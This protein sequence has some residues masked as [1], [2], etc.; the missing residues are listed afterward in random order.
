[1]GLIKKYYQVL[2]AGIFGAAFLW[3]IDLDKIIGEVVKLP[4]SYS[5]IVVIV[6]FAIIVSQSSRLYFLVSDYFDH[7]GKL[8]K[9]SFISQFLSNFLPGAV[10]G[11]IYKIWYMQRVKAGLQKALTLVA[12][13]RLSGLLAVAVFGGFAVLL[14]DRNLPVIDV[15]TEIINTISIVI[16]LSVLIAIGIIFFNKKFSTKIIA[17]IFSPLH[18]L[19]ELPTKTVIYF[20]VAVIVALYI[21]CFKFYY[22][23]DFFG[24]T[25]D[26][27]DIFILLFCLQIITLAP[28]SFGGI[29][30]IEFTLVFMLQWL[31]VSVGDA[32]IIALLN[33]LSIWIVSIPGIFF[34]FFEKNQ[35]K[36]N[37][38]LVISNERNNSF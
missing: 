6:Q 27:T 36:K 7:F 10:G 3:W 17:V 25:I 21:R 15:N 23:A 30:V 11:D 1:M 4:I 29:G 5:I 16:F 24:Y 32:A 13:D 8:L 22:M 26:F 20:C 9:L 28:V 31:G 14:S 12:M 38:S 34:W 2:F 37:T 19:R 35:I 18:I 33:R